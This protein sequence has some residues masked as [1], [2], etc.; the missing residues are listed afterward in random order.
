MLSS[1]GKIG[2][3]WATEGSVDDGE[4][5][6]EGNATDRVVGERSGISTAPFKISELENGRKRAN[7]FIAAASEGEANRCDG[8]G[9]IVIEVRF[10]FCFYI[11]LIFSYAELSPTVFVIPYS[12]SNNWNQKLQQTENEF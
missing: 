12:P 3:E 8:F 2:K 1:N 10:V 4:S 9:G 5:F 11:I 6:F 7:T